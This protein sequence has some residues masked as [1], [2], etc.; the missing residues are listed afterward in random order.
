MAVNKQIRS[1]YIKNLMEDKDELNKSFVETTKETL[2]EI[3]DEAVNKNLRS[4][5]SEA[6]EDDFEEEEVDSKDL[7]P[8][9]DELK[10]DEGSADDSADD[11]EPDV[12]GGD[13]EFSE[14]DVAGEDGEYSEPDTAGDDDEVWSSL[15][16]Y[17]DEDGEYDLT[18]MASD[19]VVKVLKVMKPEDG[20]RVRVIKK[21]DGN[22]TLIDDEND[23]EYLIVIGDDEDGEYG[24]LGESVVN[25]GNVDLGYTDN[26]QDKTAMTMDPD[27]GAKTRKWN[28]GTPTGNGKRWVGN[29]GDMSPYNKNVNEADEDECIIEVEMD[30]NM[31]EC[32]VN[33]KVETMAN[34]SRTIQD[35][36]NDENKNEIPRHRRH[37]MNGHNAYNE[38][39]GGSANESVKR[40][41]KAMQNENKQLKEIA[42]KMRERL[43]EAVVINASL[44]KIV[45]LVTENTTTRDEKIQIVN[46]FNDVQTV[47]ESNQLYES[48]SKELKNAH[49]INNTV[50]K[51]MNGMIAESKKNVVETQLYE[52]DDLSSTRDLMHRLDKIK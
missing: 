1:E 10:G 41:L 22:I 30:D 50:D 38:A 21:D 26:Y 25:E 37:R 16:Q 31:E 4:L 49:P 27:D 9:D 15:E 42:E 44:G 36:H 45:K 48:I 3:V 12:A 32:G 19:D 6:D 8:T 33:E 23:T 24:E 13:D 20:D 52:C 47:K 46:R 35:L 43:N 40:Q 18:S 14:P 11:S 17:K 34:G 28:A 29:K 39:P 51:A 2:K 7:T 5:I